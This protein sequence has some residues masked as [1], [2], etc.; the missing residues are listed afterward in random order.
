MSKKDLLKQIEHFGSTEEYKVYAYLFKLAAESKNKSRLLRSLVADLLDHVYPNRLK[1]R[2]I[3][4]I[5]KFR[6]Q[7]DFSKYGTGAQI[8]DQLVQCVE[9][10]I[11]ES[12]VK[13]NN[14]R[15][16]DDLF[17][18][19]APKTRSN[20]KLIDKLMSDVFEA[21]WPKCAASDLHDQL[22]F[23]LQWPLLIGLSKLQARAVAENLTQP[24]RSSHL[25]DKVTAVL[26]HFAAICKSLMSENGVCKQ[27]LRSIKLV[28]KHL[29]SSSSMW[30]DYLRLGRSPGAG[31]DEFKRVVRARVKEIE[32]FEVYRGN[33]GQ[34]LAV[35]AHF[36][37]HGVDFDGLKRECDQLDKSENV[38][39]ELDLDM[40]CR[41]A[42]LREIVNLT[43]N[44][45]PQ[46]VYFADVDFEFMLIVE[47]IIGTFDF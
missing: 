21:T 25:G 41:S 8:T 24:L 43:N 28:H 4:E 27:R 17:E 44:Y 42:P 6:T 34:L 36:R 29:E 46:I 13:T 3:V 20:Q 40:I 33:L 37:S 12:L 9:S 26:A 19:I 45:E 32:R 35:L 15:V 22:T 39:A 11:T 23:A 31:L 30:F 16:L 2:P 14:A 38:D 7:F 5:I 10:C 1:S 18:S 47:K